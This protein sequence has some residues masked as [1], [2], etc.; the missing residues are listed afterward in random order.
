MSRER[1]AGWV[2][3]AVI[4]WLVSGLSA[5]SG[6]T[7]ILNEAYTIA[8]SATAVPI[9][10]SFKVPAAGTY[11]VQLVDL[12]ATATPSAPLA[13]VALAVT[14]G[15]VIVG[16]PIFAAGT[17]PFAA[18][19]GATYTLHVVGTPGG[20]GSGPIGLQVTSASGAVI[21]S[22]SSTLALPPTAVASGVGVVNDTLTVSSSGNYQVSLYDLQFPQSL[23]PP[24]GQ[25]ALQLLLV[26]STGNTILELSSSSALQGTA[27]L[28]SGV[29]YH[30]FAIG[31]TTTSAGLYS[32]V[33]TSAGT[34][35][36][37]WTVPL[38]AT[39]WLDS[40]LALGA[41]PETLTVRDLA[42]PG[43]LMQ[44]GVALVLGGQVAVQ[45][46]TSGATPFTATAGTYQVFGV[47]TAPASPGA[48]SYA[49]Q[50]QAPSGAPALSLAQAV[51]VP[52][53][54]LTGYSFSAPIASAGT[55][56]VSLHDYQFPSALVSGSLATV[57]GTAL[58][59][60]AITGPGSFNIKAATGSVTLLAF[61]EGGQ[62]GSLMDVNVAQS[63]GTLIFDQPQGVGAAFD[64]QKFSA[65]TAG[66]YAITASDLGFPAPFNE[67]AVIVTQGDTT[68]GSIF[69]GG[70]L[71]PLTLTA[72]NYFANV[73]ASPATTNT[74]QPS[75]PVD[76]GTY[77]LNI[78][79][80]LQAL[81]I[82]SFSADETSVASGG[83]V[84]LSWSTQDATSCTGSGGSWTT[85][86]TGTQAASD[87]VTSPAISQNTTF[88]LTCTGAGGEQTAKSVSIK[89]TQSGGGGSVGSGWLLVLGACL[90]A[91]LLRS[92]RRRP[93]RL[94]ASKFG[95]DEASCT[96]HEFFLQFRALDT[97][98]LKRRSI[99][100]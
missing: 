70:T 86:Y 66:S 35:I 62:G 25:A 9:E 36:Q 59:G 27:A 10:Y 76:S 56:T 46:T 3:R 47:A 20:A 44:V 97:T 96:G 26:D 95:T 88:T 34:T 5:A 15:D 45:S 99:Q 61:A 24:S 42:F 98:A 74:S 23:Q 71:G 75:A 18:S 68:V 65:S 41:G 40:S 22:A 57:Q 58:L 92:A 8:T 82:S 48:G 84:Q 7:P 60:T 81:V 93:A 64:T 83:T 33:V 49:V 54:E 11:Q 73:V 77:A 79:S 72:G 12:G 1:L 100:W 30:V 19:G 39:T 14:S 32:A 94:G 87:T 16:T 52:A 91:R 29:T 63:D 4:G 17:L 28:Q 90:A 69:G 85:T 6:Q 43:S 51:T 80:T 67:L 31:Q 2:F 78:A 53:G 55:Y 13:A 21:F 89:V 38:G 37:S 50:V